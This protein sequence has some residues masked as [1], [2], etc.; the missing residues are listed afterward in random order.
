MPLVVEVVRFDPVVAEL[1]IE[2]RTLRLRSGWHRSL[3][4]IVIF[5]LPTFVTIPLEPV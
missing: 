4:L 5:F 2:I 1:G 3:H